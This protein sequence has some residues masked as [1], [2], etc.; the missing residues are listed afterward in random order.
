MNTYDDTKDKGMDTNG[1][2]YAYWKEKM[3]KSNLPARQ[4]ENNGRAP[5]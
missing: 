3:Q 5:N 1:G 4:Y 2:D